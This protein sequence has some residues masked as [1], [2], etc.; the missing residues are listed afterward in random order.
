MT[1]TSN[2][3]PSGVQTGLRKGCRLAA[4]K[5]NG[6]LLKDAPFG[7]FC[8]TFEPALAEYASEDD[9]SECVICR[10]INLEISIEDDR[11]NLHRVCQY[12]RKETY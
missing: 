5:L 1:S 6:N 2:I 3:V 11:W 10:R 4:Q 8:E 12:L 9:H 7:A